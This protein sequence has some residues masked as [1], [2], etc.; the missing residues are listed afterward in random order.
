[1]YIDRMRT[2]YLRS[3]LVLLLV[4]SVCVCAADP[5]PE[6]DLQ[7]MQG[8]HH[9]LSEYK[10][11]VVLLNFWATWCTPCASEMPLLNEMQ[12]KYKDKI[13]VLAAS[14]DDPADRDK[15]QPFL[16]QH[17]ADDLTLMVG[18]T[19]DTLSDFRLGQSLPATVFID[20]EGNMVAKSEGA[21]KRPDLEKRLAEMTGG[22]E[23]KSSN[24][25]K[26]SRTVPVH[27]EK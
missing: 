9:K 13:I 11:K 12:K 23:A 8:G 10:G 24:P 17:K 15:L 19:L 2:W 14:I 26:K 25:E 6:L 3:F 5:L 1:M 16:H 22:A 7:D 21:L 27:D 4:G 20:Q 18:P